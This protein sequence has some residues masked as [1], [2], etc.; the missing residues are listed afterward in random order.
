MLGV[1]ETKLGPQI[2]EKAGYTCSI[3]P[4]IIEMM[5]GIRT[6]FIK[7]SKKLDEKT[8]KQA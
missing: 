4:A 1:S 7:F 8:I 6:H 5:R 3:N 2:T